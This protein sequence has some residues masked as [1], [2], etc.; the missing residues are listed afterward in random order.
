MWQKIVNWFKHLFSHQPPV[1]R[2][3]NGLCWQEDNGT[4]KVGLASQVIDELGDITFLETPQVDEAVDKNDQL[5]DIEGGKAVETFKSPVKGKISRVYADYQNDP[6]SLSKATDPLL[7][8][9]QPA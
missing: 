2:E 6:A 4:V 3:D 8:E 1:H 7:V 9:I 5:I